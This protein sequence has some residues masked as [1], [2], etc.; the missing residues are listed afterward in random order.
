MNIKKTMEEVMKAIDQP[1]EPY[2]IE[3]EDGK[4]ECRPIPTF[5]GI[6]TYHYM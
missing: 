5:S 2:I 6:A 4:I 3:T 1:I